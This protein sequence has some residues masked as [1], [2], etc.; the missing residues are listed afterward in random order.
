MIFFEFK[1]V[2]RVDKSFVISVVNYKIV[3][4]YGF[5]CVVFLLILFFYFIVYVNEVRS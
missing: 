4:I 2:K 3:D 5:V 1:K